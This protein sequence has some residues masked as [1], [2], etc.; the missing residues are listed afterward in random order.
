[1]NQRGYLLDMDGVIYRENHLLPGAG[2]LI[3]HLL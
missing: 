3:A 2:E 1:M